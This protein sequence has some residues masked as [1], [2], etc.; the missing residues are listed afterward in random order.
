MLTIRDV[1]DWPNRLWKPS[2]KFMNQQESVA[3]VLRRGKHKFL[4]A[5]AFSVG[6]KLLQAALI[7]P[8]VAAAM[9]RL[10]ESWGRASVGNFEIVSFLLSPS[11]ILA[12]VGIGGIMLACIYLELAGLMRLLLNERLK[13][14]EALLGLGRLFPSLIRLGLKQLAVYVLLAVPFLAAIGGI[15]WWLWSGRDIYGLI[16]M[17]TTEFWWGAGLAG[18]VV[19]LYLLAAGNWFTRWLLAVPILLF[20]RGTSVAGALSTSAAR[21]RG[22]R[23]RLIVALLAW[24]V[25]TLL[26]NGI[27]V[28]ALTGLSSVIL[29]NAGEAL[30]VVIPITAGLLILHGLVATS[31]SV[32]ASLTFAGLALAWYLQN[33]GQALPPSEPVETE[34]VESEFPGQRERWRGRALLGGLILLE[35]MS[36]L[37]SGWLLEPVTLRDSLEITAHRA[38]STHAPENS[39]AAL[40]R[41]ISDGA[42]WAEI[43]VQL[44]RDSVLVVLHDID[45]ARIGGGPRRVDSVTLSEIR[46]LDIGSLFGPEFAGERV[47]TL[48]EMLTAAGDEIRMNIELKPHGRHDELNLAERVVA[49]IQKAGMVDRCRICSQS[50]RGLQHARGIE[51]RLQIG[52]IAGAAIGDLAGL[53]VDFLMVRQEAATSALV[54]RASLNGMPV[55]AWTV[56]DP[57]WVAPLLDRGVANIITDD[58]AMIRRRWEEVRGLDPMERLLLRARNELAGI[59]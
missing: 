36:L 53:N 52:F 2:T 11:G 50:Y 27:V 12:L 29:R 4:A 25:A 3:W 55:H 28:A 46:E 16:V 37:L 20:E 42:D 45:L 33:L 40:R 15:Y 6:F 48:E 41:A 44:S 17:R 1:C 59:Q 58:P 57:A 54:Q 51:P 22:H 21:T 43:D 5:L 13:S 24:L 34:S 47:P 30:E 14:W 56:S 35:A 32:F 38:G 23:L 9:R 10:L 19:A 26:V 49:A 39:L 8:I 7:T 18:V 31:L